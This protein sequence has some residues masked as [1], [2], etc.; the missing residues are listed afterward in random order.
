MYL[1]SQRDAT[2]KGAKKNASPNVIHKI[3]S[4]HSINK[5]RNMTCDKLYYLRCTCFYINIL[6]FHQMYKNPD[7]MPSYVWTSIRTNIY[8]NI[9]V[10]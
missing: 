8:N 4:N 2:A 9:R 6:A 5:F 3:Y 7:K 10:M 1:I